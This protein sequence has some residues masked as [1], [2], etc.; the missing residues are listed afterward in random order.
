MNIKNLK[1]AAVALLLGM[2]MSSCDDFLDRPVEDNYNTDNFYTNDNACLMGVNYLYNSPWYD[3]QR[4]FI[5]VGEV[6]SGNMY[7]GSSPYLN[8]SVN[9]TNEDLVNMSYSLWAEI[10]HANTVYNNLKNATA[11]QSIIQQCM[12]ECLAWKAMAYFFLVRSFG[13]VPIIHDNASNMAS[14]DYNSLSKV[15]KADVYEYILMTLE[16]AMELLPKTKSTTGRIDYYCAEG[17][18]AKVLLTAAGVSGSLN[19]TYLQKASSASLDVIQ[20]S[21]RTLMANYEDIFRGSNNVSDESLFAWRWTVG[22]HWTCQNTQQSDLMP[23]GFDEFGDCW[24]GWGGPS[25]DLQDAFGYDVTENP[26]K[27]I[28]TDA[29]RKATMMGPGDTY[30]YFW[31][32]HDLGNGKKGLDIL[33]FYFDKKYN[34]GATGEFQGP[35]GVQNVKHAYGN[36]ADHLAECGMS[37]ARMAYAVA[38]HVL[39]LADVYLVHAEAEVLQGKTTSATALEAFDAV[40]QRSVPS[41]ANKTS[42]TFDDIWKERRLEFAGEGDRWYDFVRRAYYDVNAC[43]TELTNQRRNAIWGCSK[44]YKQYY[45][46]DGTIWIPQGNGK[47][48]G[49]DAITGIQYDTETPKPNVTAQSFILPYPTEDVALNPNLGSNVEP[50]HVDVREVYAY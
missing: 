26:S 7:W 18:Y 6:M 47:T 49:D 27:R 39:R 20:N 10:A 15:Q 48:E 21:G 30:S 34:K 50:I 1:Y 37:A 40:R 24:G 42:L 25:A 35:C 2:G 22:S 46:S 9:G 14:G 8:F 44:V 19:N 23:E 43:I 17:L 33:K 13:D 38:T 41:A 36:N 12:G 45:E 11:S 3:F 5:K 16:K 4:G 29:R 28:D 32:D 31:R